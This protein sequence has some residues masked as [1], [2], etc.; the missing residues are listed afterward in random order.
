MKFMVLVLT[1]YLLCE[2]VQADV[3]ASGL[4]SAPA[5]ATTCTSTLTAEL[6]QGPYYLDDI[7]FRSNITETETGIPVTLNVYLLDTDCNPVVDAFISIWHANATG[8]YSG[9]TGAA[10]A[11][12]VAASQTDELTFLRGLVMTDVNGLATFETIFPGRYTGR[13]PHIHAKAFV[14]YS[15]ASTTNETARYEDSHMVHT[16][17]FFN[18]DLLNTYVQTIYPYSS[19]TQAGSLMSST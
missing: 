16:G 7:L 14:P 5:L 4:N 3:A 9:F 10:A 19:N 1:L 8:V 6:T 2:D 15:N 11:G 12:G 18:T 13:T 17:Q